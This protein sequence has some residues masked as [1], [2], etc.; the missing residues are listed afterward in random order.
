MTKVKFGVSQAEYG[1]V[2][3]D[4]VP[5]ESKKLPG[6]TSAQLE[7]TADIKALAA[8]DGPYVTL[9]GGITE[10]KLTLENYDINSDAQKDFYGVETVNGISMY[11][12]NLA[13]NDI[14]LMFRTKDEAGKGIWFA[15]LKAKYTMPGV[16][17]KTVDG[18]P[19]PTADKI[20][21]TGAPR[22]DSD[23]GL[24]VLVGRESDSGFSLAKFKQAVFPKTAE[25]LSVLEASSTTP[26]GN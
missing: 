14:A 17:T 7:L 16:D 11:K 2:V 25:D 8:D 3:D 10:A 23:T 18:T 20:E 6:M 21:G 4:F 26:A 1:V 9:S 22:G 13:P 19:D 15:L 5:E 12:K 24:M